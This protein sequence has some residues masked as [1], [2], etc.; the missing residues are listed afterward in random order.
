MQTKQKP[1]W[2]QLIEYFEAN[3][4]TAVAFCTER[5]VNLGTF[6][7]KLY[8]HRAEHSTAD[9]A[10]GEILVNTEF[11]LSIDGGGQ[12]CLGGIEPDLLPALIKAWSDV[13]S[14]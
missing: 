5:G 10:F 1:N 2:T 6:R 14:E 12:V 8:S 11:S 9:P 4:Q 7:G 3:D 13:I